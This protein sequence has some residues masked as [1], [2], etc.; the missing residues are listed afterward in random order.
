M[1][2]VDEF[3]IRQCLLAGG[4]AS[5]IVLSSL[6]RAE[7]RKIG[8]EGKFKGPKLFNQSWSNIVDAGN[9]RWIRLDKHDSGLRVNHRLKLGETSQGARLAS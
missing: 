2:R 8:L 1:A 9:V 6:F 3:R 5:P 7:I 4:G